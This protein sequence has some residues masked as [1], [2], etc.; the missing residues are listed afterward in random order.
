MRYFLLIFGLSVIAVMLIA[1]KRG[2]ISR[3]PPLE[4]FPD[5]DKMPKLRPQ[6]RANFFPDKMSSR[7]PV[8]GTV[9]FDPNRLLMVWVIATT[10]PSASAVVRC[11]VWAVAKDS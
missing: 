5:M 10:L 3:K 1:G 8:P 6:T 2:D 7:L 4:I 11:V 9:A